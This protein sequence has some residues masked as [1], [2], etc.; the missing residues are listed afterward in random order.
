MQDR[1]SESEILVE[2][3]LRVET[4]ERLALHGEH[5]LILQSD[6]DICARVDYA[7]VRY[8]HDTHGVIDRIV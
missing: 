6:A 4:E 2:L 7:L 8:R 3:I 1:T 5:R